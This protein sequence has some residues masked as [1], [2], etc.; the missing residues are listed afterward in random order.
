[1]MASD[2]EAIAILVGLGIS[3][4]SMR[5]NVLAQNK[6]FIRK[7]DK[8]QSSKIASKVLEL[9]NQVSVRQYIQSFLKQMR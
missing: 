8:A 5:R 2:E 7:L 9:D 3:N 1:M 6:A 4:F